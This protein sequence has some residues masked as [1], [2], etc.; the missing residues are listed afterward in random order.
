MFVV[1]LSTGGEHEVGI[2]SFIWTVPCISAMP[3][4]TQNLTPVEGLSEQ[5]ISSGSTKM[6]HGSCLKGKLFPVM[7]LP[8][9]LPQ[10]VKCRSQAPKVDEPEFDLT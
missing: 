7:T 3:H 5:M 1:G 4:P 8:L 10:V 6:S 9:S 2:F